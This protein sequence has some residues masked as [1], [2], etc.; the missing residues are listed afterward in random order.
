MSE[1]TRPW[2]ASYDP[3]VP[4]S[5]TYEN[6]PVFE[7]LDRSAQEYPERVAVVFKTTRITYRELHTMA[8]T[9]AANLRAQGVRSGDRVAVMLPN[10][11]QTII[12][13]WGILKA[14]A[15]VVMTN[16]LYREKE[17]LHQFNDAGVRHLVLLDMLWP[18]ISPL[19]DRTP[20]RKIFVTSIPE[21]LKFPLNWLAKLKLK[22]QGKSVSIPFDG[23]T[24]IP[25]PTLL[26]GKKR[27]SHPNI[28]PHADLA[29]LQYTGG[30]TGISKGC[31]ITHA[32]LVAN[33]S[34]IHALLHTCGKGQEVF[35]GVLPYF[36]VYGLCTCLNL[37]TSLG[38][39]MAPMPRFD[40]GEVLDAIEKINP[41][42]FP[43]APSVYI[44]LMHQKRFE[45]TDFT[46]LRY[47]VS[48][49]APMP[50][51]IMNQF[52]KRTGAEIIEGYGL[53][54]A[55]PV[56]HLNPL[57]GERKPGTIG[58]P[59]PDTDARIVDMEVGGPPLPSGKLG[60][61]V[62]K[63][64]Q[65]MKGYWGRPD[66]TAST[67]RNGWL[68]TGDIATMDEEGYFTIVDRKKDL[69][70]SAGY[71]IYPREVDEVLYEHPAI[72]E[73]CAVGIPH[74]TR[75]EIVK[76]F[77]VLHPDKKVTKQEILAYCREKLAGYK[78]PKRVEFRPELPKTL[79]GKVL[80][81][82]LRDEEMA[83][84]NKKTSDK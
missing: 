56:T 70:I 50:L 9:V 78:V 49:S 75:G 24:V 34:Q 26:K 20:V 25:W 46:S 18:K 22:K 29:L 13:Y 35:L 54:E 30:T 32:N 53:T 33:A 71:N 12:L 28:M 55:S 36:H 59:F 63:A 64:P 82:A 7:Y 5:L 61:L 79:V 8:E 15:T 44:A 31:M 14:G 58:L 84:K 48:G 73:A 66:E 23:E 74:K 83:V 65:V 68:Y 67:L 76:A 19:R 16:P 42:I 39:T 41:T 72:A 27:Y 38:A 69:I 57:N 77:I 80:R 40:P 37:P 2:F 17:V 4:T 45:H 3:N 47:C 10:L 1:E 60:E 6:I 81:R 62:I 11:P 43:G 51:E 52:H 21:A